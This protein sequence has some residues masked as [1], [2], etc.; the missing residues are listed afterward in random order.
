LGFF[1][2]FWVDSLDPTD[3]LTTSKISSAAG[4]WLFQRSFSLASREF[5][6]WV[7]MHNLPVLHFFFF[8]NNYVFHV[9]TNNSSLFMLMS[10]LIS[11]NINIMDMKRHMLI[12]FSYPC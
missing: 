3:V 6:L 8:L 10:N 1:W 2:V 4:S 11:I 9:I 12:A 7:A 5:G